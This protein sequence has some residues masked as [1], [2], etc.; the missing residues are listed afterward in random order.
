MG[1][2]GRTCDVSYVP[3]PHDV[4]D[5][6]RL[7]EHLHAL[8]VEDEHLVTVRAVLESGSDEL[9]V[10]TD[11][12]PGLTLDE[13][14]A[15]RRPLAAGEAVTVLVPVAQ[16]LVA[17]HRADRVHG[18]LGTRSVVLG[19]DGRAVVAVPLVPVAGTE[20][21]DV[22]DLAQLVVDLVPAPASSHPTF[23]RAADPQE[24]LR[25]DALHA[26]LV[27]ALRDDPRARPA[28]GT[29]A[30]RCYDAAPPCPLEMPDPAR[31]VANAFAPTGLR[32]TQA[33]GAAR[34]AERGGARRRARTGSTRRAPEGLRRGL[35]VLAVVVAG[36]AVLVAGVRAT[37]DAPGAGPGAGSSAT[38]PAPTSTSEP[39][40]L[41]DGPVLDPEDPVGAARELTQR[42]LDLL[43][44]GEVELRQVVAAGSPAAETDA[45]LVAELDGVDVLDAR[46]TVFDARPADPEEGADGGAVEGATGTAG[47]DGTARVEVDYAITAHRQRTGDQEIQVPQTPRTTVVLTV[48]WTEDGWRVSQV[49]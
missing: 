4:V 44:G 3:V 39:Q 10:L 24:A 28:A 42:R 35:V 17:L 41:A 18:A 15:A 7:V 33:P 27:E 12:H 1:P 48:R 22:R 16:A 46:A 45:A 23:E 40:T 19:P 5:R 43:T 6:E 13:L 25:L 49:G 29:F 37:S 20:A 31:L 32:Q 47:T 9:A 14:A 30:A 34:R 21:D 8:M 26:E 38:A 36:C 2:D 11:H